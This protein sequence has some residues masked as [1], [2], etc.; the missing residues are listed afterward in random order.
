LAIN[1]VVADLFR[2]VILISI[3]GWIITGCATDIPIRVFPSQVS[4]QGIVKGLKDGITTYEEGEFKQAEKIFQDFIVRHPGSPYL[5][6]AQWML[7]QTYER[8]GNWKRALLEYES[9]ISNFRDNQ[10]VVEARIRIELLREFIRHDVREKDY[11]ILLGITVTDIRSFQ[12][13]IKKYRTQGYNTIV[14]DT[15]MTG[16][17]LKI[18]AL[19]PFISMAHK[20][21]FYVLARINIQT[22][23]LFELRLQN[24][25]KHHLIDIAVTGMDGVLFDGF[26]SF[27]N[28]ELDRKAMDL[29]LRD[30]DLKL[31][32]EIVL[33]DP[34]IYWRWVGWR[35]R[36]VMRILKETVV[37]I[38]NTRTDFYWG[39]V[40]PS[41]AITS[42]HQVVAQ[43]GLD[44]LEAKRHGVDY[45][46][47]R[48]MDH[49]S[50][51]IFLEKAKD[52]IGNTNR[53]VIV[54]TLSEVE[55]Q[56]SLHRLINHGLLHLTRVQ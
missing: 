14:I 52:L 19:I 44:L 47:I 25:L 1:S 29:F 22:K 38:L 8:Q 6:E 13:K 34:T 2:S 32:P 31:K 43:T 41:E 33:D 30:S 48:A 24:N 46:V 42:P 49:Q 56:M 37:P 53:T 10:H 51:K 11:P 15:E 55:Q 27:P 26:S 21:G 23:D 20:K 40:F 18:K 54:G 35:G 45:F 9:L 28:E 39:V 50:K 7:G 5:M 17:H 4:D 16:K 12:S 3:L 36:E